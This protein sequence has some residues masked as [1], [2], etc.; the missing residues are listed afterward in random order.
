MELLASTS[1]AD[2]DPDTQGGIG[3]HAL[4]VYEHSGSLRAIYRRPPS[5]PFQRVNPKRR[6]KN[7]QAKLDRAQIEEEAHHE[8]LQGWVS[9]CIDAIRRRT[10]QWINEEQSFI[11]FVDETPTGEADLVSWQEPC[12]VHHAPSLDLSCVC[13]LTFVLDL[14]LS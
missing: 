11:K 5:E 6:K 13:S 2:P 9:A 4:N 14:S 10:P 1:A 7:R 3:C 12:L 8:A